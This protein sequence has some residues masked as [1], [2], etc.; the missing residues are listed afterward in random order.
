MVAPTLFQAPQLS[1]YC[2]LALW[3]PEGPRL[4]LPHFHLEHLVHVAPLPL[5]L[6]RTHLIPPVP[7]VPLVL[8]V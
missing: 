7:L 1:T 2:S 4:A 5:P 3:L 6:I 8:S